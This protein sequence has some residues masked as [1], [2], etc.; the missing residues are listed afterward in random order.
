MNKLHPDLNVKEVIV[1]EDAGFRLTL[2]KWKCAA[3]KDLNSLEFVQ[4]SLGSDGEVTHNSIYNFL[5]TDNELRTL[6]ACI[7]N[8][9]TESKTVEYSV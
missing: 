1:K 6:A 7:I 8:L 3:P 2:R 5:M 4:E 9:E